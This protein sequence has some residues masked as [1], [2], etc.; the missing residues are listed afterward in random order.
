MENRGVVERVDDK[1]AYINIRRA[2]AWGDNCGSCGGD[3]SKQEHLVKVLNEYNA[4]VGDIVELEM[5]PSNFLKITFLMY[6]LPG[7]ILIS[8]IIFMELKFNNSALAVLVSFLLTGISYLFINKLAEKKNEEGKLL[9]RMSK[10]V[11]NNFAGI[12]LQ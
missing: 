12:T 10:L 4:G 8:S 5:T 9:M 2:S 11:K 3:C 7:I 6:G 1:F